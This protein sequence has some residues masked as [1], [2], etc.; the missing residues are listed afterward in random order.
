MN[1]RIYRDQGE[2]WYFAIRGNQRG[3]PFQSYDEAEAALERHVARCQQR[4]AGAR[5]TWPR[6]WH[7]F[8]TMRRSTP[9][10]S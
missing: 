10:H 5:F 2:H 1:N 7:P 9:R 3:G 8:K 6:R 4:I